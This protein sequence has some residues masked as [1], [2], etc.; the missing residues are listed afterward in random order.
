MQNQNFT[1][2]FLVDQTPNEVFNAIN[3]VRGWWSEELEGDSENL[4]DEFIY[5]HKDFHYSKHKLIEVAKDTKVV[6]LTTDSKLTFINVQDEWN[7]TKMIFEVS[8]QNEQ[9][10]LVVTHFGLV[11]EFECYDSCSKGWT[12]YLKNS[13]LL[14]I[15]TGKGQPDQKAN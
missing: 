6:W 5:R 10:K 8:K 12:Y 9:T 3:N 1:I 4:N 2:T 11:P 13:L 14:L 7:G 15:T